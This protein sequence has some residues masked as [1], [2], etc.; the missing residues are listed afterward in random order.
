MHV[1]RV[2]TTVLYFRFYVETST[3]SARHTEHGILDSGKTYCLGARY[4]EPGA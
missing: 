2:I 3:T 1:W 4:T